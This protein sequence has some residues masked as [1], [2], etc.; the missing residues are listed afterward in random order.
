MRSRAL[1]E[2]VEETL[3]NLGYPRAFDVG[4]IIAAFTYTSSIHEAERVPDLLNPLLNIR[5]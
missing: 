3:W 4:Y 1:V 2:I 5:T